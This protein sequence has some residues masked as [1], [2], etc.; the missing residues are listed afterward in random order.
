M[1]QRATLRNE[2]NRLREKANVHNTM[3]ADLPAR[4]AEAK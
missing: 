1:E 2:R 4:A 3:Q